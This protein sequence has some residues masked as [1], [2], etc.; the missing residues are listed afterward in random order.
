MKKGILFIF[1]LFL[2]MFMIGCGGETPEIPDEPNK[3]VEPEPEQHVHDLVS[4]NKKEATC[5]EDGYEAYE[6]CNGCDYSTFKEIKAFGHEYEEVVIKEAKCLEKGLKKF[7]CKHDESHYYEEEIKE[8]GHTLVTINAKESTCKENG[9]SEYIKCEKCDY[10]TEYEVY[11]MK[12]HNYQF[13]D[14]ITQTNSTTARRVYKC[15]TCKDEKYEYINPLGLSDEDL[16]ELNILFIGN[17]YTNY[18][19][20]ITCFKRIAEG[21][22]IKVNVTKCAYGSQYLYDYIEGP[23]GDHF[24][25]LENTMRIK[26]YDLTFVQGQSAEPVKSPG[27]FYE[28][29]RKLKTYLESFGTQVIMYQTWG[30]PDGYT[31]NLKE[32]DCKDTYEMTQKLAAA[33]E[34]IAD[35]LN[36]ELSPAGS[37]LWKIHEKYYATDPELIYVSKS[38]AHPSP[39]G[40]Y[41]IALCHFATVYGVNPT[42][43]NYKF[44][45]YIKDASI[46]WHCDKRDEISDAMQKALEQAA[47]SAVYGQSIVE[48][49]YKTSS[50]GVK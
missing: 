20:L 31:S 33:Y 17:S 8:T 45:D 2:V 48:E 28:S 5:L 37:A 38:N 27:V 46:T 39:I 40:T 26:K 25:D 29:V 19:T 41:V 34:A 43:V 14:V 24:D 36:L 16:Q 12:E 49:K 7:V 35:E 47:Y 4:F 42:N 9:H 13:D 18:N 22:G 11:D 10:E 1:I 15:T 50:V 44:N 21:Q 30:Y 32:I 23:D 6:K 3:P